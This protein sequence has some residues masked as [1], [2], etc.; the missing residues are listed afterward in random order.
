MSAHEALEEVRQGFDLDDQVT[1]TQLRRSSWTKRLEVRGKLR[2]AG[3]NETIGVVL[4][5]RLWR[6]VQDLAD[7]A[8]ALEEELERRE[9]EALWGKR[10]EH[11]RR[12]A[13]TEGSRLLEILRE[14]R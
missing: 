9:I 1:L 14:P 2:L 13:G 10:L 6:G 4:S 11:E 12:P 3:H 8:A 5:P 7:Y